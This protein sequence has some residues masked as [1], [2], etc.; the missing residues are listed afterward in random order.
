MAYIDIDN[1][2]NLNMDELCRDSYEV[3]NKGTESWGSV[4]ETDRKAWLEKVIAVVVAL[5]EGDMNT[6]KS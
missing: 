6:W 2:N 3:W 4:N 5:A 1:L